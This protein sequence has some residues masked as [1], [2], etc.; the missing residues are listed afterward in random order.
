MLAWLRP[1]GSHPCVGVVRAQH[2]IRHDRRRGVNRRGAEIPWRPVIHH[3]HRLLHIIRTQWVVGR[4]GEVQL[5]GSWLTAD[6]AEFA[7]VVVGRRVEVVHH[8]ILVRPAVRISRLCRGRRGSGRPRVRP[9]IGSSPHLV[10]MIL[11]LTDGLGGAVLAGRSRPSGLKIPHR[12]NLPN[13][14]EFRIRTEYFYPSQYG[15][16]N[17]KK[18]STKNTL[19]TR[20]ALCL[21]PPSS[22][23]FFHS[24]KK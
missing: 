22:M 8:A 7:R 14:R 16:M 12:K 21:S 9:F 11:R 24:S 13:R 18:I 23:C 4:R 3:M 19:R 6:C 5:A 20:S 10:Q 17:R 2:C 1:S 15:G